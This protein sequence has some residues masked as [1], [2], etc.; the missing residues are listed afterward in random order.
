M[1]M[2]NNCITVSI[3]LDVYNNNYNYIII[4]VAT[5]GSPYVKLG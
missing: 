3:Y 2:Q 1:T 4:V 5:I